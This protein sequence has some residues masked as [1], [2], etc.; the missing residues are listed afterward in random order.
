MLYAR[1]IVE[2]GAAANHQV[3]ALAAMQK[4]RRGAKSF[5]LVVNGERLPLLANTSPPVKV[6]P[7][8]THGTRCTHGSRIEVF[9]AVMALRLAAED[10][11]AKPGGDGE[12]LADMVGV[13]DEG[14][15][16]WTG[17]R[18]RRDLA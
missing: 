12:I 16:I 17:L 5:I 2:A 13:L 14:R 4:P 10:V 7:E 9:Q 6:P 11:P 18:G 15:I 1:S 8:I 3:L